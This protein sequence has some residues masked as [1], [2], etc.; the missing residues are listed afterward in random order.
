MV[1]LGVDTLGAGELDGFADVGGALAVLGLAGALQTLRQPQERLL[2][3]PVLPGV[4]PLLDEEIIFLE[5]SGGGGIRLSR[6]GNIGACRQAEADSYD[7][8]HD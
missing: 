3:L 8:Q 7:A 5:I 6:G 4:A 1:E 2:E